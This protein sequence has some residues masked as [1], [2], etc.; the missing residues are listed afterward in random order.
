MRALAAK[1]PAPARA[2]LEQAVRDLE[3]AGDALVR[4]DQTAARQRLQAALASLPRA[5]Q[6][7]DGVATAADRQA[8]NPQANAAALK[9]AAEALSAVAEAADEHAQAMAQVRNAGGLTA[10]TVPAESEPDL[11]PSA[12]RTNDPDADPLWNL[13]PARLANDLRDARQENVPEQYRAMINAYFKV[14]AERS[15]R[16]E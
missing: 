2:T 5:R 13:L 9:S 14:V 6:E 4:R 16:K 15:R 10:L 8:I 11:A 7:L 12:P 3:Q 1:A